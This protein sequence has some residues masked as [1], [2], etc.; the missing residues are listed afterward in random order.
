MLRQMR[1]RA[2]RK[3]KDDFGE[4]FLCCQKADID[5]VVQLIEADLPKVGSSMTPE[6]RGIKR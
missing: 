4:S 5:D 2:G 1:G 6:R 3:G